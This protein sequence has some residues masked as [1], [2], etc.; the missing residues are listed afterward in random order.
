MKIGI[1]GAGTASA[2]ALLQIFETIL[3]NNMYGAEVVCIYNP[4]IPVTHV[5]ESTGPWLPY[6]LF[7]VLDFFAPEDMPKFDS[8]LRWGNKYHWDKNQFFVNHGSPGMHVN[9]EKFS[10][11]VIN[12]LEEMY[13]NFKSI[14]DSVTGIIQD[15]NSVTVTGTSTEYTFDYLIDCRGTPTQEELNS[16]AYARPDFIGVNS[17]ILY[18]DFKEY[19]EDFTSMYS[20]NNGWMF[21]VPLTH[22]KAF[23]YLYNNRKT[24]EQDARIDFEK[25]KKIDTTDL[26]CF[27]WQQYYRKSPLDKRVLYLGNKLFFFEPSGAIPLFWYMRL[28]KQFFSTII[29]INSNT[30]L[31]SHMNKIYSIGINAIQDLVALNYVGD[32]SPNSEFW[33]DA[34]NNSFVRLKNSKRF[35][36]WVSNNIRKQH[37][38]DFWQWN[39]QTM[40]QYVNGYQI[41]LSKFL[42]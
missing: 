33:I 17:V 37:Y 4:D 10:F 9:S 22:R 1:I 14:Q 32:S 42:N 31:E 5:G 2:I 18:P 20:H 28:T 25:L 26:R 16:D 15:T 12:K 23:G 41:D 13:L 36:E 11:Y 38:A 3:D 30:A 7:R 39:G 40:Q 35:T 6:Q 29:S 19:K 24:T 8:T 27:T 21:G 34:K